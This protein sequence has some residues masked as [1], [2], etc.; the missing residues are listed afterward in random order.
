MAGWRGRDKIGT[1]FASQFVKIEVLRI[2]AS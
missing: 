2:F 1:Y